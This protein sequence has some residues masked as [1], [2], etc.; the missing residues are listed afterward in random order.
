MDGYLAVSASQMAFSDVLIAL[1]MYFA[2]EKKDYCP[3]RASPAELRGRYDQGEFPEV[4]GGHRPHSGALWSPPNKSQQGVLKIAYPRPR[5][6]AYE[7][8]GGGRGT[9]N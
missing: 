7:N 8:L 3:G 9:A 5:S 1:L 6:L 2:D 4:D